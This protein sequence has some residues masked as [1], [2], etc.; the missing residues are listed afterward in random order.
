MDPHQ[1]NVLHEPLRLAMAY[2]EHLV[3]QFGLS[4]RS[5]VPFTTIFYI[6]D[7]P[8]AFVTPVS[9][10]EEVARRGLSLALALTDCDRFLVVADTYAYS[11][12][13]VAAFPDYADLRAAFAAGD[14][15]THEAIMATLWAR[16]GDG[17]MGLAAYRILDGRHVEWI[18]LGHLTQ[19]LSPAVGGRLADVAS[20]GFELQAE[21]ATPP[22]E[23]WIDLARM[24]PPVIL[25]VLPPPSMKAPRN[26]PCPCGSGRKAKHC[27]FSAS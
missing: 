4:E 3:K 23:D 6:G 20:Q 12:P 2:K 24:V 18:D 13:G 15:N 22:A 14:P 10:D 25:H 27:C 16:E 26:A 1:G 7:E 9:A 5:D 17:F 11:N 21:R 8:F 19:E